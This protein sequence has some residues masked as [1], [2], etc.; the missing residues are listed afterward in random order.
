MKTW[1]SRLMLAAAAFA[2]AAPAAFAQTQQSPA[3]QPASAEARPGVQVFEPAF[4]ARYNPVTAQDMVRQ[5]PGFSIDDGS[6]VRGFGATAGNV[7]VDGERPSSKNSM[8]DELARIPARAVARIELINASAAG[9]IDVRGFAQIA[10]V[11]LKPSAGVQVNTLWNGIAQYQQDARVSVRAGATRQWRSDNI[12]VRLNA[13][14]TSSGGRDEYDIRTTNASGAVLGTGDEF[15]QGNL[16]ELLINGTVNWSAT[17]RDQVNVTGRLMPRSFQ[18]DAAQRT[19]GPTGLPVAII[20]DDYTEKDILHSELGGDWEHRFS[21]TNS[22]K[23]ISVNRQV[24]WR[25]QEYFQVYPATG[26]QSLTRINSDMQ[27]GEH[28]LRGVWTLKPGGGHTVEMGLEGAFNYRDTDRSVSTST[29]GPFT[30]AALPIASTRVE[31]TRGEAF[32]SDTW[33]INP[34]WTLE[35]GFN[36]EA[37]RITQSGDANQEREFTYPKPRLVATWSPTSVDQLRLSLTRDV[38]QLD[39]NEFASVITLIQNQLTAGNPDLRPEQTTQAKAVWRRAFGQRGSLVLTAFYDDV[40]DVQD[41]VVLTYP[42]GTFTGAG[43]IGDGHRYGIE[44]EAAAPL[45][46][47]GI[48][49]G[50][51]KFSGQWTD[52]EVTD[53][54]SGERRV[55]ASESEYGWNIDFRQDL[56]GLK[57]AWGGDYSGGGSPY[58][59]FRLDEIFTGNSGEGDL[60]LFI[61]T[62]RFFG[63]TMRAQVDNLGDQE[64]TGDRRFFTPNRFPPGVFTREEL[65]TLTRGPVYTFSV[66]GTF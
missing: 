32:I 26:G 37:S 48:T 30:P 28:V 11:V 45:D 57:L 43:N 49:G 59:N 60:D 6:Q 64:I 66:T 63:V 4:F 52:S 31:E 58:Y 39:F 7:L 62:T 50:L 61:E 12:V 17:A 40:E 5:L 41:F 3:P 33:V 10:N 35:T 24:V 54:I 1:K 65:R 56:P 51:L 36:Y 15:S 44:I 9:D 23:L 19:Y 38:A 29:G 13:Q 53:P 16:G 55:F 20:A 18:R 2:G 21:G 22:I 27:S 46:R 47:L 34:Q 25:P 8:S 42:G 14:V